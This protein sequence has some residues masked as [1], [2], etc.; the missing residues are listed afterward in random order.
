[1]KNILAAAAIAASAVAAPCA[2]AGPLYTLYQFKELSYGCSDGTPL[3][4]GK[5]GNIDSMAIGIEGTSASLRVLAQGPSSPLLTGVFSNTN[6]VVADFAGLDARVDL[7]AQTCDAAF[8][9]DISSTFEINSAGSLTGS[10]RLTTG[11]DMYVM[12]SDAAGLWSGY[13]MSDNG[14]HTVDRR[15][16]F[17]GVFAAV[18]EPGSLALLGIGFAGLMFSMRRRT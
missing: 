3:C 8:L 18:P 7:Q 6:V 12:S 11:F 15:P 14:M 17:S 5:Q 10:F 9:C 1:M 16:V 2:H 4:D 13:F